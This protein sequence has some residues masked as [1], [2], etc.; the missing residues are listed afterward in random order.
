MVCKKNK[1]KKEERGGGIPAS[2]Y[3]VTLHI[4]KHIYIYILKILNIEQGGLADRK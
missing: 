1:N 2:I 3:I 4:A